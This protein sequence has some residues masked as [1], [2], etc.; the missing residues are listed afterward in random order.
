MGESN[1][2]TDLGKTKTDLGKTK[3]TSEKRKPSRAWH[4]VRCRS[5]AARG[6]A[7]RPPPT[8]AAL[9][10]TS[11]RLPGNLRPPSGESRTF[12]PPPSAAAGRGLH[13]APGSGTG[14]ARRTATPGWIFGPISGPISESI[15]VTLTKGLHFFSATPCPLS[16]ARA[17]NFRADCRAVLRRRRPAGRRVGR[18]E[19][20]AGGSEPG[21][22]ARIIR[23]RGAEARPA[24]QGRRGRNSSCPPGR[25]TTCSSALEGQRGHAQRHSGGAGRGGGS[26]APSRAGGHGARNPS[27]ARGGIR[28]DMAG[29]NDLLTYTVRRQGGRGRGVGR[30]MSVCGRT[31]AGFPVVPRG[32]RGDSATPTLAS[33]AGGRGRGRGR[34]SDGKPG[35]SDS[36]AAGCGWDA[37]ASP[38]GRAGGAGWRRE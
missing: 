31:C 28:G 24:G 26:V 20:I 19:R 22:R 14:L 16:G 2:E 11:G 30:R 29:G 1:N 9:R 18:R 35:A 13:Q 8:P 3:P 7:P 17:P 10:G 38:V 21:G 37:V 34:E 23:R 15:S 32:G 27:R 36:D 5:L 4:S 6:R 12:S 25:A 33:A